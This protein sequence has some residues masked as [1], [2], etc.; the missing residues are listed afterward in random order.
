MR[1]AIGTLRV[2]WVP[3]ALLGC[4]LVEPDY[5]PPVG[6]PSGHVEYRETA[7]PTDPLPRSASLPPIPTLSDLEVAGVERLTPAFDGTAHRY[8]VRATQPVDTLRVVATADS[9]FSIEIAGK[10][11][12]SGEPTVLPEAE[13]GSE[14]EIRVGNDDGLVQ[15]YTL[16][17]LPYDFPQIDVTVHEPGASSDPIYV[18]MR[19]QRVF[20]LAK[21]DENGVPLFYEKSL[22]D[23]RDFKKHPGGEISY[24]ENIGGGVWE[25][26]LLN[27]K[28][29]EFGRVQGVGLAG[30]D[31]HDFHVRENGNFVILAYEPTRHDLT[32]FGLGSKARIIDAVL[33]EVSPKREVLF[34]WNSWD[35]LS[36]D[37]SVRYP[38]TG[39]DYTHMNSTFVDTDGNWIVSM[40][41]FSQVIKINRTT[42]EVMWRLGGKANEFTFLDDPSDGFCGQHTVRRVDNGNLLLF[43]NGVMCWPRGARRSKFT[44]IVE[45][46]IDEDE[47]TAKMVWS[48]HRE[49]TFT[50]SAGSAQR[51]PNGNTFIGWGNSEKPPMATEVDRDGNIVFEV[52]ARGPEKLARSYRAHRIA[53]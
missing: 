14:I 32:Q 41:N 39:A 2:I 36:Y 29:R 9:E 44:R 46:E 53:D 10:E 34:Q 43:D 19:S 4:A 22:A 47:K 37:E 6:S 40:R 48:F 26:V 3:V 25:H 30:T 18:A 35:H 31:H 51:L 7:P 12:E 11:V 38:D 16:V 50:D 42:G 8:S 24:A 49:G 23:I 13:P 20:H 1:A 15:E 21:L 33:Q 28:F 5:E 45:Y 52:E 17:Y 27:S